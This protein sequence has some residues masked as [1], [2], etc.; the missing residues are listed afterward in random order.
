MGYCLMWANHTP[1]P[2]SLSQFTNMIQ[3]W[4]EN[5]LL[6]PQFQKIEGKPVVIVF[7]PQQ[8]RSSAAG[9][10]MKSGELLNLAREMAVK[11]GLPGIYFIA[12]TAA[13]ASG[14]IED[15]P[16]EG[17]DALTA[18]NYHS[19]GFKG[20]YTYRVSPSTSYSEL[21]AGYRSQWTWIL[22]NSEIPYL[23]PMTTG[24]DSRPWGSDTPHDRSASTP[25]T[26][27]EM[28]VAGKE[29]MDRFPKKTKRTAIIFAWNEFGEGGYI[30]PTKKWGFQYLQAVKDVFGP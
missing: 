29:M 1:V 2:T 18:Y 28:L 26:F 30:M 24:W 12:N 3:Y 13:T 17:Y 9:F 8:L 23:I 10:G 20:E 4:L 11:E 7:S 25:A 15:I 22:D 16:G 27:R 14:V 5:Y 6:Q 19:K 21:L